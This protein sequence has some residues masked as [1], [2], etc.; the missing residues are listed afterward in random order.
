MSRKKSWT[1]WSSGFTPTSTPLEIAGLERRLRTDADHVRDALP[2]GLQ[3]RTLD[4][5]RDIE[6]N[7]RGFAPFRR[8]S[9][10]TSMLGLVGVVVLTLAL[11]MQMSSPGTLGPAAG[12]S[13]AA[14]STPGDVMASLRAFTTLATL[15]FSATEMPDPLSDEIN[16]L[17]LDATRA[18]RTIRTTMPRRILPQRDESETPLNRDA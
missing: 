16:S 13:S 10:M 18:V 5:L 3:R 9:A 12:S 1:R 6:P 11:S 2:Q 7:R 8:S 17:M 14:T 15:D 4:A